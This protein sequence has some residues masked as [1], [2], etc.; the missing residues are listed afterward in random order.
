MPIVQLRIHSQKQ[1]LR[2]SHVNKYKNLTGF[3]N[4]SGLGQN[5]YLNSYINNK[6]LN[7]Q[8]HK[9]NPLISLN[10]RIDA[11]RSRLYNEKVEIHE[12][13]ACPIFILY[14]N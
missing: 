12:L 9:E 6:F 8:V 11:S 13:M 2:L 4:L 7:K 1:T 14:Y 10:N 5:I 3:E